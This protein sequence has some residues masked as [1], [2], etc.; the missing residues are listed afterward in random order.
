MPAGQAETTRPLVAMAWGVG[1]GGGFGRERT[2]GFG[3]N[4][5][6]LVGQWHQ[7]LAAYSAKGGPTTAGRGAP[8]PYRLIK[9]IIIYTCSD[10]IFGA[11]KAETIGVAAT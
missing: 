7:L 1:A 6:N 5:K 10:P 3:A 11:A 4:S 9:D 8:N 2:G